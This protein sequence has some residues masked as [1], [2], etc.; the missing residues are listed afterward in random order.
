MMRLRVMGIPFLFDDPDVSLTR[1]EQLGLGGG[2]F[3]I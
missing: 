1:G 2:Q 3:L